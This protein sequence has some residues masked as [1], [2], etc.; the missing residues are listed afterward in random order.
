MSAKKTKKSDEKSNDMA[1]VLLPVSW[2]LHRVVFYEFLNQTS[3]V[4]FDFV[5]MRSHVYYYVSRNL[6]SP[7][8]KL[9]FPDALCEGLVH[10]ARPRARAKLIRRYLPRPRVL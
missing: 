9:G 10:T 5:L 3:E 7:K 6:A 1:S 4:P 2:S 8:R